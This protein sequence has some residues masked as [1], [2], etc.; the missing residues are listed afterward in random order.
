[1]RVGGDVGRNNGLATGTEEIGDEVEDMEEKN[2]EDGMQEFRAEDDEDEDKR[3]ECNKYASDVSNDEDG[4]C[5][6]RI[7]SV[8]SAFLFFV[9]LYVFFVNVWCVGVAVIESEDENGDG[10]EE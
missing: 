7:L 10:D 5:L 4:G 1:M 6:P 2:D 8:S 9:L 3:E